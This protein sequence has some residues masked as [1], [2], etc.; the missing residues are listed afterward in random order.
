MPVRWVSRQIGGSV[1]DLLHINSLKKQTVDGQAI[2]R[3]ALE[4]LEPIFKGQ[5]VDL[6]VADLPPVVGPA[7][8]AGLLSPADTAKLSS[9]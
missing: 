5:Q 6:T 4:Q 8:R 7:Q 2:V 9:W 3:L 1:D